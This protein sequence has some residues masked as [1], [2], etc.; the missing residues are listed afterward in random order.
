MFESLSDKLSEYGLTLKDAI[1]MFIAG[2]ISFFIMLFV[3]NK[4]PNQTKLKSKADLIEKLDK[5]DGLVAKG[6]DYEKS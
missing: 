5:Q 3:L 1:L 2:L 6:V 4:K